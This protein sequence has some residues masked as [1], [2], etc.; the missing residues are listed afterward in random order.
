MTGFDVKIWMMQSG[1]KATDIAENHGCDDSLVSRF[2]K[3]KK[4]SQPLVDLFINK[5]CPEEYFKNGKVATSED[6]KNG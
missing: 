3:G 2:L 5:G 6:M 1:I 4:T